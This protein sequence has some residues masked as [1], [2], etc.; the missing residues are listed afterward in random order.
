MAARLQPGLDCAVPLLDALDR[1]PLVAAAR[2][3]GD[4]SVQTI[5]M[6]RYFCGQRSC[7]PGVGGALVLRDQNHLTAA[8]SPAAG[9]FM[10][11]T[12]ARL[13]AGWH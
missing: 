3:G 6:T 1:D 7:Y 13:A 4:V 12:V 2:R 10:L 5:D 11:R 8:L 9:P